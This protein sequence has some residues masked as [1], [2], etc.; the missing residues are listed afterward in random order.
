MEVK[1]ISFDSQSQHSQWTSK[2]RTT[3]VRE[4]ACRIENDK[5]VVNYIELF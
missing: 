4:V 5:I 2:T 3:S 1:Q